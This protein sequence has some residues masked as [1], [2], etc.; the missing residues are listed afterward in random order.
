VQKRICCQK[1]LLVVSRHLG[2]A[3]EVWVR[4]NPKYLVVEDS[5]GE[6]N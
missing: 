3:E 4:Y 6:D 5:Q 1:Q 2:V